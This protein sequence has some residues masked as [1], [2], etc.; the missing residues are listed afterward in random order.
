[1]N[2]LKP[3]NI[4]RF[5]E[6]SIKRI[7]PLI[8]DDPEVVKFFPDAFFEEGVAADRKYFFDV[9][10]TIRPEYVK[11]MV[12]HA[13]KQRGNTETEEMQANCIQVSKNWQEQLTKI[14]FYSRT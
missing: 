12:E 14:P 2:K 5:E 4:L 13:F 6:L 7:I 8:K 11:D 3:V 1:M 10:A 9:L